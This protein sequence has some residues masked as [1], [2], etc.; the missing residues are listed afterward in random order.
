[1]AILIKSDLEAASSGSSPAISALISD[2]EDAQQ[3]K[4]SIESFIN[5]SSAELKGDAYDRLRSH[6]SGYL[7][8]LDSRIKTADSVIEAIK[9]ANSKLLAYMEDED[10]LDSS[11]LESYQNKQNIAQN[12]IDSLNRMINNYDPDESR[13]TK[14]YLYG[15]LSVQ[16][17]NLKKY[18]KMVRLLEG[19][20]GADSSAYGELSSSAEFVTSLNT[21]VGGM[22]N[23]KIQS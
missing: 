14:D 5:G 2:K 8:V 18:K 17:A 15:Q 3:L 12:T 23:I 11:E 20:E 19:L 7:N 4:N 6:M 9:S 21:T 1:M 16:E 13:V 10:K 22:Q